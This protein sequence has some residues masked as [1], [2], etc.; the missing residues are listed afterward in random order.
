MSALKA[1]S[2]KTTA[3]AFDV[4]DFIEKLISF[5]GG[6]Q[7]TG[8]ATEGVEI[9]DTTPL[10]WD[11]IGRKALAKSRRV[12]V[13]D[14]MLGPLSVE[15]KK[16]AQSKRIR[17]EKHDEDLRR[18][19]EITEEDIQRSENE[20]TKNVTN[21]QR[22]LDAN[23]AV[24]L[25]KFIINPNDFAQSVENLF[26]LSF[27]IRDGSCSLEVEKGEPVI[28]SVEK[29]TQQEYDDGLT[30]RQ[31]V[32]EFDQETWKRAIEVYSITECIVPARPKD[33]GA[34][35]ITGKRGWYG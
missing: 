29:P 10:K 26:Y 16:R 31:F 18:P 30:R 33:P 24:N 21:I 28:F 9:D 13:M 2:M 8:E 25:F 35:K 34:T 14:F 19:Q 32:F 6:N 22:I 20:T 3:G 12:P 4:E 17:L 23:G 11:K 15:Q 5:M 27:L 7:A 1:R